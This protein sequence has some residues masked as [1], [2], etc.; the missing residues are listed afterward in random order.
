MV[1]ILDTHA[2]I[3]ALRK[4]SFTKKQA[5]AVVDLHAEGRENLVT[6]DFFKRE[7]TKE[8]ALLET[9]LTN[10]MYTGFT[11]LGAFFTALKFFG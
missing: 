2:A 11:I 4:V 7:L 5:E 9:K 8:L 10:R 1:A 3:E 6:K